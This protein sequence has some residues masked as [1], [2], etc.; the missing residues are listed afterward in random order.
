[1]SLEEDIRKK[2]GK[3]QKVAIERLHPPMA[4]KVINRVELSVREDYYK[5][6]SSEKSV[7]GGSSDFEGL[8]PSDITTDSR[9][10][11][12]WKA[13]SDASEFRRFVYWVRTGQVFRGSNNKL[14]EDL[15][16]TQQDI[17]DIREIKRIDPNARNFRGVM[18]EF[19]SKVERMRKK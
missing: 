18:N 14:D 19:K 9:L 4:P 5:E 13:M 3:M 6:I 8:L 2:F 7:G 11:I 17:N 1:M 16:K 10:G 15:W 12:D